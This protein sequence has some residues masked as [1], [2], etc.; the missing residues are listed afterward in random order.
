MPEFSRA[1]PE[2]RS[3][4]RRK[5]INAKHKPPMARQPDV[6]KRQDCGAIEGAAVDGQWKGTSE[7]EWDVTVVAFRQNVQIGRAS[8]RE[9]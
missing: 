1:N 4:R 8:C 7:A 6:F 3:I 9:R 5:A 2:Y